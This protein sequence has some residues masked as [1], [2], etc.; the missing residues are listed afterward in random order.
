M[1]SGMHTG[2]ETILL[3]TGSALLV[4][5]HTNSYQKDRFCSKTPPKEHCLYQE[6][7]SDAGSSIVRPGFTTR[8]Q[9][10][11]QPMSPDRVQSTL[12]WNGRCTSC[13]HTMVNERSYYGEPHSVNGNVPDPFKSCHSESE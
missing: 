8:C 4:L 5:G 11:F 1:L 13:S 9:R 2:I 3:V 12:L 6:A 7:F 10:L